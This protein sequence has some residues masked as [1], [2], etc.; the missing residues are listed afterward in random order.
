MYFSLIYIII[1]MFVRTLTGLGGWGAE[2]VSFRGLANS[3]DGSDGLFDPLVC[4]ETSSMLAYHNRQ[5]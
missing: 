2:A 3:I 5:I 4:G 1:I